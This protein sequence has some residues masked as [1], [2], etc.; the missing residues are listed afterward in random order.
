M[1]GWKILSLSLRKTIAPTVTAGAFAARWQCY[2]NIS[3]MCFRTDINCAERS[4]V[5]RSHQMAIVMLV[6]WINTQDRISYKWFVAFSWCSQHHSLL[7]FNAQHVP[8]CMAAC[9]RACGVHATRWPKITIVLMCIRDTTG[10][11]WNTCKMMI[12][13][14]CTPLHAVHARVRACMQDL[15]IPFPT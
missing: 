2:L 13:D 14:K 6:A 15:L 7:V 10:K 11:S 4:D 8:A 1:I 5:M 12:F 3:G 9:M